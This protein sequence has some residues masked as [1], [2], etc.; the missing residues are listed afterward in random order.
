MYTPPSVHHTLYC[1]Y[2]Q[3]NSESQKGQQKV[4]YERRRE[5]FV[6]LSSYYALYE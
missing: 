1:T 5:F 6:G 4:S 3:Y 2:M